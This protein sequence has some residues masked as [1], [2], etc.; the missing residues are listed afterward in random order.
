METN[1]TF[2]NLDP[3]EGIKDHSL[4]QFEKIEKYLLKPISAHFIFS[5]D[6]FRQSCELT[7]IDSGV[8]YISKETTTDMYQSIDQV[9]K[10]M[11][12]QLK[13]HKEKVKQHKL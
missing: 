4:R 3:T 7:L 8:E 12:K 11:V 1:F 2:R 13:K 10:K 6:K 5:L 9:I